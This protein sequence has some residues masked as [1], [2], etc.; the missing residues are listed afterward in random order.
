ME[1]SGSV[2][3]MTD[4][5]LGGPKTYESEFTTLE[6]NTFFEFPWSFTV[7]FLN[8]RLGASLSLTGRNMENLQKTADS[9]KNAGVQPWD[10]HYVCKGYG[11][12][13]HR[14]HS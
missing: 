1:G 9:C 4:P 3:I 13:R 11:Y 12:R 7:W 14:Y 2:Q 10:G 6:Y 5:A 8:L